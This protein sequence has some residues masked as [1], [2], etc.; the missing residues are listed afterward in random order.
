MDGVILY[1][2]DF[3]NLENH[4][5]YIKKIVAVFGPKGSQ[6]PQSNCSNFIAN[7]PAISLYKGYDGKVYPQFF[8]EEIEIQ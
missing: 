3:D 2:H 4:S 6:T 8:T 7:M 1:R 5:P